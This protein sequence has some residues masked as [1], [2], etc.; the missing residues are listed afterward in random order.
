M[1]SSTHVSR[2]AHVHTQVQ[3]QA[4]TSNTYTHTIIK[5]ITKIYP[6]TVG[7]CGK[8]FCFVYYDLCFNLCRLLEKTDR[9]T[10][11]KPVQTRYSMCITKHTIQKKGWIVKMLHVH[12]GFYK[13]IHARNKSD[14]ENLNHPNRKRLRWAGGDGRQRERESKQV[15]STPHTDEWVPQNIS[16]ILNEMKTLYFTQAVWSVLC[17]CVRVCLPSFHTFNLHSFW[18][19]HFVPVPVR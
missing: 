1:L 16:T 4:R 15:D 10:F 11:W 14:D 2:C 12:V 19:F 5:R 7:K 13:H 3:A 9:A 6:F 8:N 18:T 17:V